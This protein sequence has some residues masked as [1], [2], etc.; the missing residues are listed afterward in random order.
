MRVPDHPESCP[1]SSPMRS[2]R[3]C[4]A[5]RLVRLPAVA[6]LARAVFRVATGDPV[7]LVGPDPRLVLAPEEPLVALAQEPERPVGDEP[8]LDDQEAV[9]L[10]RRDLLRREGV[11][12]GHGPG[13]HLTGCG[14]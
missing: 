3:T 11:H 8:L 10:E 5:I 13:G 4:A 7:D 2:W 1:P 14:A 6:D 12:H 9:A